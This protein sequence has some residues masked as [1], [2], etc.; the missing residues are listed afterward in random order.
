[1]TGLKSVGVCVH[2]GS[3]ILPTF[4]SSEAITDAEQKTAFNVCPVCAMRKTGRFVNVAGFDPG[5]AAR[6]MREPGEPRV[7]KKSSEKSGKTPA[8]AAKAKRKPA[9]TLRKSASK[10]AAAAA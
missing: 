5:A 3:V 6:G 1:M 9:S 4:G 2:C 10:N 7:D 8:P